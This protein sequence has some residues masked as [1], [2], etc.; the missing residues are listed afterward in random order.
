MYR[1]SIELYKRAAGEC[2]HSFFEISQTFTSVCITRQKHGVHVFYIFQKTPRRKKGKQL[3]NFDYQN[4]ISLCSRH[5]YVNSARDSSVCPSSYTNTVFNQSACV[6]S[7]DCFLNLFI[8]LFIYLCIYVF[9]YLFISL[10]IHS[11]I[12][13]TGQSVKNRRKNTP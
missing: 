12:S 11:F 4:V 7:Q 6:L 5:H 13:I 3:V 8:Y 1:V 9:L 2:F 10:F